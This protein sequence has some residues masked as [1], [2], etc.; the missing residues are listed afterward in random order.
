MGFNMQFPQG[1]MNTKKLAKR[2][3]YCNKYPM[4]TE[5]KGVKMKYHLLICKDNPENSD[6]DNN[7]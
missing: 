6:G 1:Y 5:G 4:D 3:K 7:E 2:C